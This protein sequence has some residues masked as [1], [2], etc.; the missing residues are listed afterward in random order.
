MSSSIIFTWI[1]V[2][3][4]AAD[5]PTTLIDIGG[6]SGHVALSL[7]KEFPQM[8]FVVQDLYETMFS[9]TSQTADPELLTRVSFAKHDYFTPE[10]PDSTVSAYLLRSCLHNQGDDNAV[11]IL[12][13]F[14]PASESNPHAALLINEIVIQEPGIINL[15]EERNLRQADIAMLVILND[16]RLDVRYIKTRVTV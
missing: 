16:P 7:A 4:Q 8:K 14:V 11:K 9:K 12:R 3:R 5:K 15:H 10:P 6:G 2:I 1:R 13:G